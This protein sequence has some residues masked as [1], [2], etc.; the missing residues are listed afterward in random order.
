MTHGWVLID[1]QVMTPTSFSRFLPVFALFTV[2]LIFGFNYAASKVVLEKFPPTL[3]GGV[4][5]LISAGLMFMTSFLFVPAEK[6]K[7]N[8]EFLKKTFLYGLFGMALSQ[9][10]FMYGIKH[11]TTT[12]SAI[13]NTMTPIF[14]LLFAVIGGAEKFTGRRL[15]SFLLAILGAV[16]IRD[17]SEF[18]MSSD[19]FLGDFSTLLNCAS[20]ALY[21]TLSQ[22]FLKE[23]SPF[24]ATAWM[25]LFGSILLLGISVQD[26][27]LLGNL[28]VDS[29]FYI[30]AVYNI[31]FATLI[32]Y[33]LNAWTLTKVSPS[34]VAVFF[35][36]Q[37]VIAVFNG[38]LT[39]GEHPTLR[40]F[41]AMALIFLGVGIGVVRKK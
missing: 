28:P 3:W 23:N 17:L 11:T 1:T 25:F 41:L 6:R 4:R 7:V 12:N 10:F 5:L 22:K 29:R 35:Y 19:T 34:M 16:V 32:T 21:F 8:P 40:T 24:W 37:P 9:F 33:F 27:H 14:T 13:M 31:V 39:F 2:Q 30:A 38:W 20:L 26:F 18:R 15:F 36:F